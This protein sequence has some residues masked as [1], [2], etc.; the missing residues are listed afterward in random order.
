MKARVVTLP[1]LAVIA[2]TR[3]ILGAGIGLLTAGR[4]NS[5]QR[6]RM[7]LILTAVGIASTIPLARR[8]IG[9]VRSTRPAALAS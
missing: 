9:R 4:L 8:V 7:G 6:R 1:E 3:G 5:V 2:A